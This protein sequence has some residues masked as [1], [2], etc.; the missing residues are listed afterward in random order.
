MRQ[1]IDCINAVRN[2]DY[3]ILWIFEN[4]KSLQTQNIW[5]HYLHNSDRFVQ[6]SL[7]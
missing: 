2:F 5:K 1:T 6:V 7:Y 4:I 3:K